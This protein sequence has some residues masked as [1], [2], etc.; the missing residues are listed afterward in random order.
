ML[1]GR[2]LL[3]D[4]DVRQQAQDHHSQETDVSKE[5]GEMSVAGATNVSPSWMKEL[6][7]HQ[8]GHIEAGPKSQQ[9]SAE[10]LHDP[11][12]LP[13]TAASG[14]KRDERLAVALIIFILG[15]VVGHATTWALLVM[16]MPLPLCIVWSIVRVLLRMVCVT[17]DG[18]DG[19]LVAVHTPLP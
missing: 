12:E 1:A 19:W 4:D 2:A 17:F 3:D 6:P 15:L 10:R 8:P 16:F 13:A 14:S 9:R 18:Q 11:N 5:R 7:M